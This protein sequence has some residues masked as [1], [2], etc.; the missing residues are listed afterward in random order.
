MRTVKGVVH[1]HSNY[2]ADGEKSLP[3][4]RDLFQRL[5][6]GFVFLTEHYEGFEPPKVNSFVRECELLSNENIILVPGF[7]YKCGNLEILGLNINKML[8]YAGARDLIEQ[9]AAEGG[10]AVLAH[11]H[12][13]GSAIDCKEL[14]GLNGIE[15]WNCKYEG[16]AAPRMSSIALLRRFKSGLTLAYAG[17]DFHNEKQAAGL[18]LTLTA[19]KLAPGDIVNSLKNGH[20]TIRK[21]K[22]KIDPVPNIGT[23]EIILFQAVNIKQD[24]VVRALLW[25]IRILNAWHIKLPKGSYRIASWLGIRF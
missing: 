14:S 8:S 11:P 22:I 24:L 3:E 17:L 16:D 25:S 9:I 23:F 10:L 5:G 4:I 1:I 13:Y 19:G 6:A 20:F 7:E 21:G 15:I 18:Y 12:K 2:S